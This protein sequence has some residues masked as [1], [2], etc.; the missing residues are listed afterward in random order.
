[1]LEYGVVSEIYFIYCQ[2]L[3]FRSSLEV[4]ALMIRMQSI[5]Y[6]N[7]IY[8]LLYFHWA[9]C[10]LYIKIIW[11]V[12]HSAFHIVIVIVIFNYADTI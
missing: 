3:T 7:L 1:M 10:Y 12:Q 4:N 8:I 11:F 6:S 2:G 9:L 5:T